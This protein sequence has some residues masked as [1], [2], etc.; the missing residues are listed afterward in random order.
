MLTLVAALI[1]FS[2]LCYLTWGS[3]LTKPIAT[4]MLPG[5]ST[6]VIAT[7]LLFCISLFCSYPIFINPA[8]KIF[9]KWVFRCKG[10]KKKSKQR[11]WFKNFQRFLV[12]FA[13]AYMAVELAS[14]IDKFLG[15]MGALLC[16]PLALFMP[17][18]VHLRLIAKRRR[19][20]FFDI[21]MLILSI[22]VLVFSTVQSI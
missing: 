5:D 22:G 11:Y 18:L 1:L 20:I 8:N 15:L 9:E 4:E 6:F 13:G 10:L 21:A 3:D 14:K 19:E 2:E 17:A 12:V 16:A 7:K